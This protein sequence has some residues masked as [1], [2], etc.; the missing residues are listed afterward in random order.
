MDPSLDWIVEPNDVDVD[1]LL[2]DHELVDMERKANKWEAKMATYEEVVGISI[3]TFG[4]QIRS[5]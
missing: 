4:M 1:L 3:R 5:G 2:I